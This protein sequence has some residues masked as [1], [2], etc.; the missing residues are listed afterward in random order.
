[1]F[2]FNKKREVKEPVDD[3][4]KFYLN[5]DID[6]DFN[7]SYEARKEILRTFVKVLNLHD[8]DSALHCYLDLL[9]IYGRD[10]LKIILNN[11]RIK[12]S[13]E[14][15]K[16]SLEYQKFSEYRRSKPISNYDVI[17]GFVEG[18]PINNH[19]ERK[20]AAIYKKDYIVDDNKEGLDSVL[21]FGCVEDRLKC[22]YDEINRALIFKQLDVLIEHVDFIKDRK[23]Y[24][25]LFQEFPELVNYVSQK[26]E[27]IKLYLRKQV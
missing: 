13:G 18:M 5:G 16:D 4:K 23:C 9:S 6:I 3:A 19:E 15:V 12:S 24:H 1:M 8:Y 27:P 2:W 11:L 26:E 25:F 22:V 20:K 7:L 17:V 21:S 10:G 14:L